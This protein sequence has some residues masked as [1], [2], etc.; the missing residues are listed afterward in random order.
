M[1]AIRG[2]SVLVSRVR[3]V[4]ILLIK[5]PKMAQSA[6]RNDNVSPK[7]I[8]EN[9]WLLC[10]G[11]FIGSMLKTFGQTSVTNYIPKLKFVK[12]RRFRRRLG[13]FIE[14]FPLKTQQYRRNTAEQ[15]LMDIGTGKSFGVFV[16]WS[17]S[18]CGK[19]TSLRHFCRSVQYQ[20]GDVK[21]CYVECPA[22]GTD[23]GAYKDVLKNLSR[24]LSIEEQDG[25]RMALEIKDLLKFT[26]LGYFFDALPQKYK[27]GK[28]IGLKEKILYRR[29][30]LY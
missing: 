15:Y 16:Y 27:Y 19:S 9:W 25:A 5:L 22:V 28:N 6:Q 12:A 17:P 13:Q 8:P 11:I 20:H 24:D 18:G 1:L 2:F 7:Q 4:G 14:P 23:S 10:A 30:E 26:W 21:C 3:L 29:S